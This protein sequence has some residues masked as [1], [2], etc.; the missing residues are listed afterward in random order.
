V[1]RR[2]LILVRFAA[3][4]AALTPAGAFGATHA[5]SGTEATQQRFEYDGYDRQIVARQPT[6]GFIERQYDG[7][8][9]VTRERALDTTH[10]L[11]SERHVLGYDTLDRP[12]SWTQ[13]G[14]LSVAT[15][16][17]LAGVRTT[18]IAG[19]GPEVVT[20]HD[21]AGVVRLQ[22]VAGL[23]SRLTT[24]DAAGRPATVVTTEHGQ[25]FVEQFVYE[26]QRG[27][28]V[29]VQD[30]AFA[31]IAHFDY[32]AD[33]ALVRSARGAPV[34]GVSTEALVSLA[35]EPLGRVSA[36]GVRVEAALDAQ[37]RL[38]GTGP[39]ASRRQTL[40]Y[41]S[42]QR[43]TRVE[44]AD[45]SARVM[46]SFEAHGQPQQV[47]LPGGAGLTLG[48]D[49]LGRLTTRQPSA[50]VAES[51]GYDVLGRVRWT[52]GAADA[53]LTYSADA[54]RE[55]QV[56]EAL[57]SAWTTVYAVD[58]AGE[59]RSLRYPSGETLADTRA[60]SGELS[61]TSREADGTVLWSASAYAMAGTPSVVDVGAVRRVDRYDGR[62]RLTARG[63][64]VNGRALADLRY[65]YDT[66][67]RA[68]VQQDVSHGARAQLYTYDRDSRVRRVE[69]WARPFV[70]GDGETGA[71]WSVASSASGAWSPGA[72][73]RT[74][75]FEGSEP[76]V[77]RTTS[78]SVWAGESWAPGV[79]VSFGA[80]DALGHVTAVDG[81]TRGRDA[82]GNTTSL[83]SGPRALT[84][85]HDVL[86]RPTQVM[87]ADGVGV[88]Y[89][90]RADGTR[91]TR[92]YVCP[93]PVPVGVTCAARTEAL[94][95]RGLQLLEVHEVSPTPRVRARY[96]Y[97]DD[98]DVPYA[99]DLWQSATGA[100]A[101]FVLL[102]DR[103]GSVVGVVDGTG[104]W[105]ERVRYDLWGAPTVE[106]ADT[107]A[108]ALARVSVDG[109]ELVVVASEAVLPA[110]SEVSSGSGEIVTSLR[111]LSGVLRVM[112]GT[113]EMPVGGTWRLVERGGAERGRELRFTPSGSM[114][115]NQALAL[116]VDADG[117]WDGWSNAMAST[118]VAFTWGS[119]VRWSGSSAWTG[120]PVVTESVVGNEVLF[121]SHTYE[122][123]LGV[124]HMR[125]RLMDPGTGLFLEVDPAGYGDAANMYV[126][127]ANDAVNHRDPTGAS[128]YRPTAASKAY[129]KLMRAPRARGSR[130]LANAKSAQ[131]RFKKMEKAIPSSGSLKNRAGALDEAAHA[132]RTV[133]SG[134]AP[135]RFFNRHPEDPIHPAVTRTRSSLIDAENRFLYVVTE[136]GTLI[137]G[138]RRVGGHPQGHIDLAKGRPVI[139]AGQVTILKGRAHRITNESGHYRPHGPSARKQA[140]RA[141]REAGY[142]IGTYIERF[143]E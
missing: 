77:V 21:A 134:G 2:A 99:A 76:D 25:S 73:A 44:E 75:T 35:G 140:L 32:R 31:P 50:G 27:Q 1:I 94:V 10:G 3:L 102:T 12:L 86:S 98:G 52:T 19:P 24:P 132:A 112:S 89:T 85:T 74:Y 80:A 117:L 39:G 113:P 23:M 22:A 119:G 101:R 107:T 78:T 109:D 128:K 106:A 47:G 54:R 129:S 30:A 97:E 11:Q 28:L 90:Y 57:G 20:T 29:E 5:T 8:G 103:Q 67:D 40:S 79:P 9:R 53:A 116:E 82:L 6:A 16:P 72:Y 43:L 65:G 93:T 125:A 95:Y 139:A 100:L 60:A 133:D 122:W 13:D 124:Y 105:I 118:R 137:I 136:E 4:A 84:V 41:D 96:Y 110:P 114:S 17:P 51:F 115:A 142:G 55:T 91:A 42:A 69:S 123:A 36:E 33:G 34:L 26:T 141:F 111:E 143:S 81:V 7:A 37:R 49:V 14:A 38:R 88:R 108:P 62:R 130:A 83:R 104:A 87:R 61:Q 68:V 131:A 64:W 92:E 138:P 70:P 18:R 45:G 66:A 135:R 46:S 15:Y 126:L 121:Q 127:M 48:Y 120:S 56:L 58:A 71:P 63:Y 59:R